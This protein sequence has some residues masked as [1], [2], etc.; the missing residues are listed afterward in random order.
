MRE[1]RDN[2]L[3][4]IEQDKLSL[5]DKVNVVAETILTETPP[6]RIGIFGEWGSG[7]TSFMNFVKERIEKRMRRIKKPERHANIVWFNAWEYQHSENILFS[8]V[9]HIADEPE[10]VLKK[11]LKETKKLGLASFLGLIQPIASRAAKSLELTEKLLEEYIDQRSQEYRAV[12]E[13][14]Q[15]YK[16]LESEVLGDKGRLVVFMDDLDRCS[17]ENLLRMLEAMKN[18]AC[19]EKTVFVVGIDPRVAGAAVKTYY[20]NYEAF[21]GQEFLEKI[22]NFTFRLM[23]WAFPNI[24]GIA[25]A[26]QLGTGLTMSVLVGDL[27]FHNPRKVKKVL[28]RFEMIRKKNAVRD[29]SSKGSPEWHITKAV[30]F[31]LIVHEFYPEILERMLTADKTMAYK[32]LV[33][34]HE[35]HNVLSED[36][37]AEMMRFEAVYSIRLEEPPYDQPLFKSA[38]GCLF[39]SVEKGGSNKEEREKIVFESLIICRKYL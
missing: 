18:F 22:F 12:E 36:R 32:F 25:E 21:D 34:L 4:S 29:T 28:R 1:K 39:D 10:S 35:C 9:A 7:K 17:P 3:T 27:R 14:K 31:L 19:G 2:P 16:R 20:G 5:E 15:F 37:S 23:P 6:L 11:F 26:F 13:F 24:D 8:L 38:I 30:F 33:R